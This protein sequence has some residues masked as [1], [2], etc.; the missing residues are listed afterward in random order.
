MFNLIFRILLLAYIWAMGVRG[1]GKWYWV[2]GGSGDQWWAQIFKYQNK[3]A[4]KYYLYLCH[5][6]S[7]NILGYSFV[8]FWTTEHFRTFVCKFLKN[9]IYLNNRS[10]PWYNI[11][12]YLFNEKV[13]LDIVFTTTK[14]IQYLFKG[15]M[16]KPF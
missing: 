8:D 15:S 2:I 7:T 11:C 12:L 9:Q 10:K 6:P 3:S 1:I 14:N 4:L 16:S 13:N 5:L